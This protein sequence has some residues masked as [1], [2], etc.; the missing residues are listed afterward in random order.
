MKSHLKL[1]IKNSFIPW[2]FLDIVAKDQGIF[3]DHGL[4]IEFF[5]VNRDELEPADKVAWYSDLVKADKLDAYSV[6]AWGA[7]DRLAGNDREKI[8]A[9][10][11]SSA[12]AFSIV[13]DARTG[14]KKIE[15]LAGV[16]IAVNMRTGSHYC[17]VSELEKSLP[18]EKVKVI[19]GG[20]PAKR[21]RGLIEGRFK[22]VALISPYTEIAVSLGYRSVA[23]TK[24]VDVLAFVA[25]KDMPQEVMASY[26]KSL[27]VAARRVESDKESYRPLYVKTLKETF[28]GYP[29]DIRQRVF[30]EINKIYKEIP[31]TVW[32]RLSEYPKES[33]ESLKMWMKKHNLV[34]SPVE[35]DQVV[36][37]EPL[38]RIVNS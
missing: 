9:A 11:T 2:S 38:T 34:D 4:E 29:D 36:Y 17:I 32:S 24:T 30:I 21:L 26:L 5:T 13:A 23:E 16:P 14:I 22:A 20:E 19:H 31:I 27:D 28:D 35:Y 37:V 18:Y 10:S 8:I 25:R 7:I 15:D 6:C 12:Y 1:K 33:F 3:A